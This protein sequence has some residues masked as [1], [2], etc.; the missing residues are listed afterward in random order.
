MILSSLSIPL[1]C[2]GCIIYKKYSSF[3]RY[4]SHQNNNISTTPFF[5]LFIWFKLMYNTNKIAIFINYRNYY[6][7]SLVVRSIQHLYRMMTTIM[8]HNNTLLIHIMPINYLSDVSNNIEIHFL[9]FWCYLNDIDTASF[10]WCPIAFYYVSM[11]YGHPTCNVMY[12][13][14]NAA[15]KLPQFLHQGF[16][17]WFVWYSYKSEVKQWY[18]NMGMLFNR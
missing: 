7:I 2:S 16:L 12:I 15:P 3:S 1:E 11:Q 5:L 13:R 14:S 17:R 18:N 10:W 6:P 9:T 8:I 4:L